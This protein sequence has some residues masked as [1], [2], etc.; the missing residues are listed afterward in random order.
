[1]VPLN[2]R[3]YGLQ[4]QHVVAAALGRA[5]VPDS[6]LYEGGQAAVILP[7]GPPYFLT[8]RHLL[9]FTRPAAHSSFR[10]S[11]RGG[12]AEGAELEES[13]ALRRAIFLCV[14]CV[15][16]FLESES[17]NIKNTH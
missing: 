2:Y 14:L 5:N 15:K 4:H 13:R 12:S 8:A 6:N 1:M 11:I 3:A 10:K 7:I 17:L 16:N 9:P